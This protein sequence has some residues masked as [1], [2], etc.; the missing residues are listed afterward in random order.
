MSGRWLSLIRDGYGVAVLGWYG[1]T[2]GF[3]CRAAGCALRA[4]CNLRGGTLS[5]HRHSFAV[6]AIRQPEPSCTWA[7]VAVYYTTRCANMGGAAMPEGCQS[8][9]SAQ[10]VIV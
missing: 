7:N 5:L 8:T 1:V 9:C 6:G 4:F 10:A 3:P 2:P